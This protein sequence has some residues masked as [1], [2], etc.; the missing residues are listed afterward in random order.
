MTGLNCNCNSDLNLNVEA[1]EPNQNA[2]KTLLNSDPAIEPI[3][4][5]LDLKRSIDT[6]NSFLNLIPSDDDVHP[7]LALIADQLNRTFLAVI[8]VFASSS[9]NSRGPAGGPSSEHGLARVPN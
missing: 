4:L 3:E 9:A 6:V 2:D 1:I 8:P 5:F 7:I